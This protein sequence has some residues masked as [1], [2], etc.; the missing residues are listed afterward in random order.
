M[1]SWNLIAHTLHLY[2][3]FG[4]GCHEKM[5]FQDQGTVETIVA[6]ATY[7]TFARTDYSATVQTALGCL[8]CDWW[9]FHSSN[10]AREASIRLLAHF[11]KLRA[12]PV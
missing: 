3:L 8:W 7:L 9:L 12:E 10:E 5:I 11:E 4:S 2:L 6:Q 1:V